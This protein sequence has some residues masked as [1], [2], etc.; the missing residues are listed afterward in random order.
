MT[1]AK[2]TGGSEADRKKLLELH[3]EYLVANGKFDWPGIKHMWS[4]EPHATFFNLNGH[5]YTGAPHWSRLWE[6]YITN[7]KGSYW[8]PFDIAG[9]IKGDMAGVWWHRHSP[10]AWAGPPAQPPRHTN[11]QGPGCS[12]PPAVE[13]P[14]RKRP[15]PRVPP[16]IS[17]V[18]L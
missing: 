11:Y 3:E 10:R 4:E 13:V 5:T 18:Q 17:A 2:I 8:T 9:E 7:V 12:T 1:D 16:P 6:F 15:E 14:K